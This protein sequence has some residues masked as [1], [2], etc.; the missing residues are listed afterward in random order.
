MG[1]FLRDKIFIKIARLESVH[2]DKKNFRG[3]EEFQIRVHV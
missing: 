3:E 1:V 2:I